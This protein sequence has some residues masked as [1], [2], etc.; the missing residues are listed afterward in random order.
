[1][2]EIKFRAWDAVKQ[3]FIY[4]DLIAG[5]MWR[6]FKTLEDRGIRHHESQQYT[7]VVNKQGKEI[8]N[9]DLLKDKLGNANE[10]YWDGRTYSYRL[11]INGEL[12]FDKTR[13]IGWAK[14]MELIGNTKEN[15]KLLK[16]GQSK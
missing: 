3:E 5:G 11:R 1:M 2:R 6:Y 15:P 7:G 8:Y 4:S 16:G 10:V 9:S 12:Q 14:F 13:F